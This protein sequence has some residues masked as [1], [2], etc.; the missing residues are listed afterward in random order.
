[1]SDDPVRTEVLVDDGWLDFQEY[2]VHRHQE[3]TVHGVRFAGVE[4]A[5]F[6]AWSDRQ[7]L[8]WRASGG[9]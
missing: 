5:K 7:H 2:F 3:P 6:L 1:M 4:A 8:G 9:T